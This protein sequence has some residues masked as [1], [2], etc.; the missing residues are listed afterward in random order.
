MKSRINL[1]AVC[2]LLAILCV[3]PQAA[4]AQCNNATLTGGW[5]YLMQ[6]NVPYFVQ[7]IP[8]TPPMLEGYPFIAESG[9]FT[10][11]GAGGFTLTD[12]RSMFALPVLH[13]ETSQG[14]YII[15][16]NCTGTLILHRENTA[17]P[18]VAYPIVHISFTLGPGNTVASLAV[19]DEAW[20]YFA[21]P[22]FCTQGPPVPC[23]TF[24]PVY[25][26]TLTKQ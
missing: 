15:N 2:L 5:G 4:N 16:P 20:V 8:H 21:A 24:V 25:V 18:G 12:T 9:L 1:W 3:A 19:V 22:P 13:D 23:N 7:L 26:G 11:D 10:F 6:Y 14:N 17:F